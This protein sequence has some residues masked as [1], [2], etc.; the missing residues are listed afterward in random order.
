M[1]YLVSNIMKWF[2]IW[3]K[4][5]NKILVKNEYAYKI[6]WID[7][8]MKVREGIL[9]IAAIFVCIGS[10]VMYQIHVQEINL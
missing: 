3:L 10:H 4:F 8:S 2:E 7:F 6:Q 5:F 1:E 9:W